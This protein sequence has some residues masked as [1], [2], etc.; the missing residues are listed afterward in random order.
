MNKFFVEIGAA[1]FDTL[2]PLADAGWKGIVVEPI[3]KMAMELRKIY[4]DTGVRV[5]QGAV[6]DFD[7]E[8]EIAVARDDDSWLSGC[9]H[10]I[11]SNH[12][13]FKLSTHP[14]RKGDFE[15]T[16]KSKCFS[17]DTLLKEVPSVDLLKVD[18][19][20]HELNI[21]MNYSFN[22]KPRVI[23]VEHK[24]VS[25]KILARKLELNGYLVWTEKDDIYAIS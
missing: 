16:I 17:L 8:V 6:S 1:N 12:L 10:V 5:I 3:P 21:F 4:Q 18:A 22:L 2:L 25:D 13:G 15:Q 9:S 14:D 23:K 11:S 24:H 7:G 19:E 20:G